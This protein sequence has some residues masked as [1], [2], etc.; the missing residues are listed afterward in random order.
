MKD[1]RIDMTNILKQKSI[2][3]ARRV[4]KE[5]KLEFKDNFNPSLN[6]WTEETG[7]SA[8]L[9][10]TEKYA[11]NSSVQVLLGGTG[12]VGIIRGSNQQAIILVWIYEP[13]GQA[14]T[15]LVGHLSYGNLTTDPPNADEWTR[16]RVS[17]WYDSP[18]NT[19]WGRV[20]RWTGSA[21]TQVGTDT[22]IGTGSPSANSIRLGR[23]TIS[24][25]SLF[26]E[27][28]VYKKAL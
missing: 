13:L 2:E 10:T 1:L 19:R 20:E 4:D 5:W 14:G 28:N 15:P 21:W 3:N 9:S 27:C 18:N 8:T 7:V 11:G 23:S 6:D 12:S 17:F 22:N 25:G 16:F 24:T 26:D